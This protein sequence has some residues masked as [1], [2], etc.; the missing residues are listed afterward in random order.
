MGAA[1]DLP[2]GPSEVMVVADER[3]DPKAVC[4][5]LLSQA[6]HGPDSQAILLSDCPGLLDEVMSVLPALKDALPRSG[7]LEQSL[8]HMRLIKVDDLLASII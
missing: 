1:Q 3:A 4:W 6:E 8:V 2:A 5:D 7:V